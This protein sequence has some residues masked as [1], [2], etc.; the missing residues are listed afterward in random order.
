MI[1][2]KEEGVPR[3]IV[4]IEMIERGIPRHGYK[5]FADGKEIGEVTS[6]TQSPTLGKNLG[7][8]LVQADY[9]TVGQE[10]EVEVRNKKNKSRS[11]CNT[12]LQ[13]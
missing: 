13:A 7:L 6:G 8:V 5:V 11:Y 3:K 1:K 2:Q 9:A 4:G 12:V 10:V